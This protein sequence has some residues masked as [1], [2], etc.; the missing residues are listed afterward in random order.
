MKYRVIAGLLTCFAALA[1][2]GA[3]G[4]PK[5]AKTTPAPFRGFTAVW[6]DRFEVGKPTL[7]PATGEVAW[8][9]ETG[10]F[11]YWGARFRGWKT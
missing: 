11:I 6:H 3:D 4:P 7:T 10:D 9:L 5:A 1:T 2:V 8:V